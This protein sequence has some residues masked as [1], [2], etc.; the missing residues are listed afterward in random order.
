V[1]TDRF[2]HPL[3]APFRRAF[4]QRAFKALLAEAIAVAG[5]GIEQA[6]G[7][8]HQLAAGP[9]SVGLDGAVETVVVHYAQSDMV[10]REDADGLAGGVEQ[11]R[12]RVAAVP[13]VNQAFAEIHAHQGH[14]DGAVGGQE[15]ARLA[16]H[17][18]G[19]GVEAETFLRHPVERRHDGQHIDRG[20]E[21]MPRAIGQEEVQ[22]LARGPRGGR[23]VAAEPRRR[24]VPLPDGGI[25]QLLQVDQA[26]EQ[27]AGDA[28][29]LLLDDVM[30]FEFV[31]AALG[32]SLCIQQALDHRQLGMEKG[33]PEGLE[34]V[35]LGPGLQGLDLQLL[36]PLGGQ[37][38]DRLPT[39]RGQLLNL[40]RQGEAVHA[41]KKDF[42]DHHVRPL[43]L[44]DGQRLGAVLGDE[45]F[46]P[47]PVQ[48][49]ARTLGIGAAV[50]DQQDIHRSGPPGL[51]GNGEQLVEVGDLQDLLDGSAAVC[52]RHG[53]TGAAGPVAQH[54]QHAQG[55]TV[56][57]LHVAEIDHHFPTG[58][59]L[60]GG[61]H[62]LAEFAV[63]TEVEPALE[64]NHDPALATRYIGVHGSVPNF[65]I[66]FVPV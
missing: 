31:G 21:P 5:I 22:N 43:V 42:G 52:Q 54:E 26:C 37:E 29:V 62:R 47:E 58:R 46:V 55:R 17:L 18:A 12:L 41:P 32:L 34:N 6:V 19:D 51:S 60:E 20:I 27:V 24:Q 45:D 4:Q 57:V 8:E 15:M 35:G 59:L 9:E 49:V 36:V 64:P 7:E 53:P 48:F 38:D 28:L 66:H 3:Q 33:R 13:D 65:L 50:V 56:E 61:I 2:H 10:L 11:P 40:P 30:P 39:G 44:E 25:R 63:G 14:D 23:Q 16:I 1:A